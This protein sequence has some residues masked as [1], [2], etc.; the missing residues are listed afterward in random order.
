MWVASL[1]RIAV[2]IRHNIKHTRLRTSVRGRTSRLVRFTA[3]EI[4]AGLSVCKVAF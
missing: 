1:W 2:M 3:D 4:K